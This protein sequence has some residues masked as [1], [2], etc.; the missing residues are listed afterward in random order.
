[1]KTRKKTKKV[2]E[3]KSAVEKPG[4][5]LEFGKVSGRVEGADAPVVVPAAF[6]VCCGRTTRRVPG[7]RRCQVCNKVVW[8]VVKNELESE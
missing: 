2:V 3:K 4:P 8:V 1:M 5:E 7:G 6:T